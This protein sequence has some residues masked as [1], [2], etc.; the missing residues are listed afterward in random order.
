MRKRKQYNR[1]RKAR[2]QII[3][4]PLLRSGSGQ[5]PAEF[6]LLGFFSTFG[7]LLGSCKERVS[8]NLGGALKRDPNLD[9]M[10]NPQSRVEPDKTAEKLRARRLTS[11]S[12]SK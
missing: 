7:S 6:G 11:N 1:P 8:A 2:D 12:F 10:Q 3:K 5:E 4:T 9:T